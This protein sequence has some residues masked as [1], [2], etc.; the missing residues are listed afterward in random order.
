MLICK[1]CKIEYE[2]G[3]KF[4]K[5]CGGLLEQKEESFPIQE[6]KI[7]TG[8][9]IPGRLLICPSC[10]STYE[11]VKFCKKCGGILVSQGPEISKETP[12]LENKQ[13]PI[14][15][16]ATEKP[17]EQVKQGKLTCPN[18]KISYDK[19]KFCIKC[20]S[21]LVR[22]TSQEKE[23]PTIAPPIE[24]KKEPPMVGIP[25]KPPLEEPAGRLF[26][27]TC[28][29]AYEAGKFCKKCGATLVTHQ[30]PTPEIKKPKAEYPPEV[31]V[32]PPPTQ[33]PKQKPPQEVPKKIQRM[34]VP[35]V[36][37]KKIFQPLPMGILGAIVLVV[38]IG[39][40]LWPKYSYLIKKQPSSGVPV[41]KTDITPP[42]AASVPPSTSPP[43][44][45]IPSTPGIEQEIEG[46]KSALE[47]IRQGNLQKNID[48]F[49]SC[50]SVEFKDREK[51][52]TATLETWRDFDYHDLSYNLMSPSIS[53]DIANARVEWLIRI[54]SRGGGQ[55]QD[56]KTL[57]DVTFK[58]EEGGWKII[59]IKSVS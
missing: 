37:Q 46:I 38:I 13:E 26:C 53:G 9:S 50:Y 14:Q 4:C 12:G 54:S 58:K 28:K 21:Q 45:E 59:E 22:K 20:G 47:N 49:M 48:L 27:P 29:V 23:M 33:L 25:K 41:A 42:P 31:K 57:L 51:R 16:K 44:A 52:K 56:R 34:P 15:T 39:Y 2:K 10:K 3:K 17:L 18:C 55:P 40:L 7:Q 19:W 6:N 24:V 32:Q 11:S 5:N 43:Q 8:G 35:P 30:M 1:K 36:K